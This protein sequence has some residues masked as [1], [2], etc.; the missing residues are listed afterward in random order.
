METNQNSNENQPTFWQ[1][2][3]W[4]IIAA[5]F[6]F[7]LIFQIK[8]PLYI[9]LENKQ[10]NEIIEAINKN[11]DKMNAGMNDLGKKIG[12]KV[13]TTNNILRETLDTLKEIKKDT[14]KISEK[15]CCVEKKPCKPKPVKKPCPPVVK[16]P[17]SV[18]KDTTT[19][20]KKTSCDTCVEVKVKKPEVKPEPKP[21]IS[22]KCY[23]ILGK[24][25]YIFTGDITSENIQKYSLVKVPSGETRPEL[26]GKYFVP[27]DKYDQK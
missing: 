4:G 12:G 24:K 13:D 23:C 18:Q 3:F 5:I 21:K 7:L 11:G 16:T 2:N 15:K 10:K 6:L 14:K 1:R 20:I 9:W 19:R 22:N 8:S 25:F 17:P 27:A 26:A